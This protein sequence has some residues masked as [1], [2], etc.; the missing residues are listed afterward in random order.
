MSVANLHG[1]FC[2]AIT[3]ADAVSL[4]ADDACHLDRVQGNE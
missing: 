2:T 3:G 4:L 1:E